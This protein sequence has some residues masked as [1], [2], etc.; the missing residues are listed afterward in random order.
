MM[1]GGL[2]C[3]FFVVN[4]IWADIEKANNDAG[5]INR[6]QA[7]ALTAQFN[8]ARSITLGLGLSGVALIG[9]GYVLHSQDSDFSLVPSIGWQRIGVS[10]SF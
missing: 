7:N 4:P 8:K 5:S 3:N 6:S 1:A 9:G 10:G 2:Y